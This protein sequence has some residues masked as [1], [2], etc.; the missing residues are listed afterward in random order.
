MVLR[1]SSPVAFAVTLVLLLVPIS[2]AVIVISSPPVIAVSD[3][4]C[5]NVPVT[6]RVMAPVAL[7]SPAIMLPASLTASTPPTAFP[8]CPA[9]AR[10]PPFMVDSTVSNPSIL[11]SSVLPLAPTKVAWLAVPSLIEL[12]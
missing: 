2:V 4:D 1:S 8:S 11:R 10:V 9:T 6:V 3:A 5:V 12:A 7:I